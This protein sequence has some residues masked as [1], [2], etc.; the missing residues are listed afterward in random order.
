MKVL[1]QMVNGQWGQAML[2]LHSNTAP[3]KPTADKKQS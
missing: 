2:Q 3:D 1:P